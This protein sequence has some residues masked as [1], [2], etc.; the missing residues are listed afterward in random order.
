MAG[1]AT[2]LREIHRLRR[3]AKELQEEI[4]RAPRLLKAHQGKVARQEET[5]KEAHDTI[6]HSKVATLEKE[7]ALKTTHQQIAKFQK[8]LNEAGGKKEYDALQAEISS[9]RREAARLEDQILEGMSRTE[10]LTARVPEQEKAVQQAKKEATQFENDVKARHDGLVDQLRQAQEQ[11]KAAEDQLPPTIR[12]QYDRMVSSRG[13]DA[14]ASVQGRTCTACYTEITA[15]S[16]NELL[17]GHF[18]I[19]KS[20]GRM[21]YLPE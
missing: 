14:L 15:Q 16:Y 10:E 3:H 8:Q 4:E 12:A 11:L 17:I 18:V 2:I 6:K 20:C 1:P 21:V 9:A 19:C 13:E 7:A 5:F